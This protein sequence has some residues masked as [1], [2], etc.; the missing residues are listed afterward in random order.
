MLISLPN[1]Y[2]EIPTIVLKEVNFLSVLKH[3][4]VVPVHAKRKK[5][6]KQIIDR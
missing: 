5:Q 1:I 2:L 3:A 4:D 6:I